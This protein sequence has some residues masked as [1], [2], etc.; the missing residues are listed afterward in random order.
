[1]RILNIIK[2]LR[3]K[4]SLVKD[5]L[6]SDA[7]PVKSICHD[8]N[9]DEINSRDKK[10]RELEAR[11]RKEAQAAELSSNACSCCNREN[12][13]VHS[14]VK[15]GRIVCDECATFVPESDG[16]FQ[17]GYYCDRCW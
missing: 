17:S 4:L 15:C 14:C 1:M 8:N 7:R 10:I 6:F 16:E 12:I 3:Y 9:I 2:K 13:A 11:S 5:V